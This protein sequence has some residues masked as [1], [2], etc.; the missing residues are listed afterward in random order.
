MVAR[1]VVL[2]GLVSL[3]GLALQTASAQDLNAG[4]YPQHFP[5]D[6]IR[7]TDATDARPALELTWRDE[8]PAR[9]P[10]FAPSRVEARLGDSDRRDVEVSF[11]APGGAF[12]YDVAL[13]QRASFT[14]D[15]NGEIGRTGAGAELR[16]GRNLERI[17]R[18]WERADQGSWYIFIASDG[19][20]LTWTAESAIAGQRGLRLQDR[21]TIGDTQVG[22]TYEFNGLQASLAY[23]RR[24]ISYNGIRSRGYNEDE[25]F[26]GFVFT[27]R[28]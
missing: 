27:Y 2:A 1:S 19:Q 16:L 20:A 13:A 23:T 9:L 24:E 11:S 14:V 28:N 10:Y 6:G 18:P 21:V 3:A 12:G 17:A 7:L 22:V 25:S 8:A 15:E 4:A 5:L 26:A